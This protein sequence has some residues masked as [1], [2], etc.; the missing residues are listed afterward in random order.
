MIAAALSWLK[1]S[2]ALEELLNNPP[3][4]IQELIA[5][6]EKGKNTPKPNN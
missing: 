4:H 1:S 6:A 3:A 2:V 5:W